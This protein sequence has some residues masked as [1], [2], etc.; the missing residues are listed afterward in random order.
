VASLLDGIAADGTLS[1]LDLGPA[2]QSSFQLYSG[3]ARR[4]RFADVL[5]DPASTD[6]P[7]TKGFAARLEALGSDH[8]PQYDLVLAWNILDHLGAESRSALIARLA[9]RTAPGARLYALV[10][11]SGR[12]ETYPLR[13]SLL[14]RD[15]VLQQPVG[16]SR[17]SHP[18]ILPAE[19]ERLLRPFRVCHAFTLRG[20]WREYVAVKKG[21]G[22]AMR[23]GHPAR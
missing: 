5:V 17:P 9:N 15:R 14:D 13:F 6:D 19:L 20:G 21:S 22:P 8:D 18:E 11:A 4:I 7:S 3:L 16:P 12:P 1:V 2:S 23:R 10:D